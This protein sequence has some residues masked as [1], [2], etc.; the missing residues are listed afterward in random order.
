[1]CLLRVLPLR[2]ERYPRRWRARN[3]DVHDGF[4]EALDPE[5]DLVV[6][7]RCF[8]SEEGNVLLF[9][10]ARGKL[11]GLLL[12]KSQHI[13]AHRAP[14]GDWAIGGRIDDLHG[15]DFRQVDLALQGR[16]S[17]ERDLDEDLFLAA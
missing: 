12:G 8:R 1:L 15:E 9:S 4:L 6:A 2:F 14:G 16:V 3:R 17:L 13:P 11:H 10:R 5:T 7:G